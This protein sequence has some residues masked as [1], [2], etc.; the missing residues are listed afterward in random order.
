M[1]S[2][3]LSI[4][5]PEARAVSRPLL[6]LVTGDGNYVRKKNTKTQKPK[7]VRNG[8]AF[9]ARTVERACSDYYVYIISFQEGTDDRATSRLTSFFFCINFISFHNNYLHTFQTYGHIILLYATVLLPTIE[10][11]YSHA[12]TGRCHPGER[13]VVVVK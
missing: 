7:V 10:R 4:H 1:H 3:N 12:D 8:D 2:E 11:V 5:V 6:K 13:E 9:I